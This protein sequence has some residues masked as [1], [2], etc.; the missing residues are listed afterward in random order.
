VPAES[1]KSKVYRFKLAMKVAMRLLRPHLAIKQKAE[2]DSLGGK[3][4]KPIGSV[5]NSDP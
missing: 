5:L 4:S 2:T 1:G 3:V